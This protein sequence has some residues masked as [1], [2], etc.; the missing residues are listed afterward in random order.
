MP[1]ERIP[2]RRAAS[3]PDG[4]IRSMNFEVRISAH[5]VTLQRPRPLRDL[6][7]SKGGRKRISQIMEATLQRKGGLK[8]RLIALGL[9]ILVLGIVFGLGLLALGDVVVIYSAGVNALVGSALGLAA[10]V[11]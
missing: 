9:G 10:I 2:V 6:F 5:Q 11:R 4:Q 7:E 8:K 1:C 3:S